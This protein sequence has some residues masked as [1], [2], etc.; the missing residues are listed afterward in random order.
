MHIA[1]IRKNG[2]KKCWYQNGKA[3]N[4]NIITSNDRKENVIVK[5][6]STMLTLAAS[7]TWRT[8]LASDLAR[9]C[10]SLHEHKLV[11]V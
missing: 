8:L 6:I 1:K 5:V 9:G 10:S 7:A 3:P 11:R 2:T 4:T